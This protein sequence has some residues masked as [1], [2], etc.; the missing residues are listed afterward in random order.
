MKRILLFI[1]L[2]TNLL[3]A[4]TEFEKGYKLG[5]TKGYKI[6]NSV[7]SISPIIPIIPVP[8]INEDY[9]SFSDGY[10]RGFVDG[11]RMANNNSNKNYKG[12][13]IDYEALE[14]EAKLYDNIYKPKNYGKSSDLSGFIE[15]LY[16]DKSNN[17]YTNYNTMNSR[18]Y[19]PICENLIKNDLKIQGKE[20]D[21]KVKET[22]I[23]NKLIDNIVGYSII[24]LPNGWYEM[25][26]NNNVKYQ[27]KNESTI[28][29]KYIYIENKN[30]KYF[31]GKRNCIFEVASST[32]LASSKYGIKL[33]YP[34]NEISEQFIINFKIIN[35][36]PLSEDPT[37]FYPSTL[38]IYTSSPYNGRDI[39]FSLRDSDE[40][41]TSIL[42]LKKFWNYSS[43]DCSTINNVIKFYLPKGN[44]KYYAYSES[45]QEFWNGELDVETSCKILNL[46]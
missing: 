32:M 43:P 44:Y 2:S 13:G 14:R 22:K 28:E 30:I 6:E 16:K 26:I 7:N 9:N 21:R 40:K 37:Y 35:N 23:N 24:E 8:K 19:N 1:L 17:N 36:S 5:Y 25:F 41:S 34:D 4:Q 18:V 38:T 39:L 11:L 10:N 29:K 12:Y 33:R 46:K 45:G 3:F 27:E 15:N 20:F 42:F 31:I